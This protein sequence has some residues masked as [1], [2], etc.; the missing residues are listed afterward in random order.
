MISKQ[1]GS[2]YF[3]AIPLVFLAEYTILMLFLSYIYSGK[4]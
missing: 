2:V 4:V 1:W 3:Y